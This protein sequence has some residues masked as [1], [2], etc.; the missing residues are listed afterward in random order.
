MNNYSWKPGVWHKVNAQVAGEVCEAL[1][2]IGSLTAKN[3]V[4]VSR[5]ED[6]PL[7]PEFEWDDAVAAEKF[8][9]KQAR[10]IIG[11][12]IVAPAER[13][14]DEPVRA[15]FNIVQSEPTYESIGVILKSPSKYEELKATALRELSR[16]QKKYR[17]IAELAPVFDAIDQICL[18]EENAS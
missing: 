15:W 16:F 4:D 3:L 6:A 8:R 17:Q 14:T 12:I 10:D 18:E 13:E 7:H 2:K 1:E 5:P 11:H 9:E